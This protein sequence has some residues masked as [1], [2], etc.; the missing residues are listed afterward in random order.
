MRRF[1]K[2]S[3]GEPENRFL[4]LFFEFDITGAE[5]A[6]RGLGCK[7]LDPIDG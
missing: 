5:Q 3:I 7:K 4:N 1:E 2:M 6:I